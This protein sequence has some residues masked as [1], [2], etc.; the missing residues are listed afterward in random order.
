MY[1]TKGEGSQKQA[2]ILIIAGS[3]ALDVF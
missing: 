2:L 1:E 3:E